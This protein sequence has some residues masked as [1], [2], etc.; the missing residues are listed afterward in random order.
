MDTHRFS[1]DLGP[2]RAETLH[3]VSGL[4]Y[5]QEVVEIQQA[6]SD[7]QRTGRKQ[8]GV[9]TITRGMDRSQALTDWIKNTR[10]GHNFDGAVQNISICFLDA[11][12]V[13]VKRM[14][15]VNAWASSWS[16]SDPSA[17]GS[18]AATETVQIEFDD[19][20]FE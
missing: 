10:D 14:N 18:D 9:L 5:G 11:N 16:A 15:F 4:T 19:V 12:K 13:A 2:I 17:T 20:Q 3:S 1:I 7:G 8:S 6:M